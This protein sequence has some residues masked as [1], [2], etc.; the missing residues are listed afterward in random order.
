VSSKRGRRNP[1]KNRAARRV[2]HDMPGLRRAQL[3]MDDIYPL[4]E[5]APPEALPLIALPA[6]LLWNAAQDKAAAAHCVDACQ[7]LHYA[8]GEYGLRSEIQA[9]RL[10]IDRD[11]NPGTLRGENPRY[12]ADGTFNGHTILI[13]PPAG[14]FI[15]PTIQQFPEV[16]QTAVSTMPLMAQLPARTSLGTDTL[17]VAR[18]EYMAIYLPFRGPERYAWQGPRIDA[19]ADMYRLTGANLAANVFDILRQEPFRERVEQSPYPR[20]RALLAALGNAESV[21][22]G[23]RYE[24]A[25]PVT[26]ARRQLADVP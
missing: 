18:L 25:D 22:A 2:R 19:H 4:M 11:G 14:R 7:T 12:N 16:P 8:L 24:F 15:D 1:K 23:G 9:V 17:A 5:A 10:R 3:S 21:V 6:V 13:V 26:E 20:L